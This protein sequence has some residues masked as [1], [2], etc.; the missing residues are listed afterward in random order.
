MDV[1]FV[2]A[3]PA[4]LA[5]AIELS[6]L[7]AEDDQ[8]SGLEIGVLEKS[9][10]IGE[11]CLSGA[12]IDASPLRELFPDVDLTDLPLRGMVSAEKVYML[13]ERGQVRLPTPP[14]MKNHGNFV[15]SICE[16]VRWMGE[17]AEAVGVNV[18]TGFPADSLLMED[19]K[20]LGVRTTPSGS[21]DTRSAS[22]AN[23]SFMASDPASDRYSSN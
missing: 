7:V 17:R 10:S 23:N 18:F 22:R 3:G 11:H 4:G 20:V 16:V 15:A 8:L 5:G 19:G 9:A 2:G 1:L 14:P 12:V 6:R 21:V 13:T